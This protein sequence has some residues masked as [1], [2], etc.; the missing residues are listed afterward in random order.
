MEYLTLEK[1]VT[2]KI[3]SDAIQI[4]RSILFIN[5]LVWL[6]NLPNVEK[7]R[8]VMVS[9][10]NKKNVITETDLVAVIALSSKD[11]LVVDWL[12]VPQYVQ[13]VEIRFYSQENNVIMGIS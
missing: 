8:A 5:V 3:L 12:E 11:I 2:H 4:A 6:A 13:G 10:K 7:L 9:G 1:P